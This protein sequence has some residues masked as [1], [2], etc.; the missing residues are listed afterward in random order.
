[1]IK[2]AS[3]KLRFV[4]SAREEAGVA[5]LVR[6]LPAEGGCSPRAPLRRWCGSRDLT[7]GQQGRSLEGL[8][9][10]RGEQGA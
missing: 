1:M 2:K 4:G 9:G 7:R 6:E 3:W 5:V 8:G 10:R